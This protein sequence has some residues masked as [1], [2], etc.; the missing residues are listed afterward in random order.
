MDQDWKAV[1]GKRI[2]AKRASGSEWADVELLV[3]LNM[4]RLVEEELRNIE[5]PDLGAMGIPSLTEMETRGTRDILQVEWNQ[6]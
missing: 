5:E 4:R 6:H 2:H 3:G 1:R